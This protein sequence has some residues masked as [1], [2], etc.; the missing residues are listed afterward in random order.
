MS[1]KYLKII[2]FL[3]NSQWHKT[4]ILILFKAPE[5]LFP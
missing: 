2:D 3:I 5:R 1:G 4:C